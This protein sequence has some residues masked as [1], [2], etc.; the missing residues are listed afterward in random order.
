LISIFLNI[1]RSRHKPIS[2][3]YNL[4]VHLIVL[5]SKIRRATLDVDFARFKSS[6]WL[7]SEASLVDPTSIE[8]SK[9]KI[10]LIFVVTK[11]DFSVLKYSL[12]KALESIAPELRGHIRLIVPTLDVNECKALFA[13]HHTDVRVSDEDTLIDEFDRNVLKEKFGKRYTWVL[14]QVLKVAAV[15][16]SSSKASLIVD[17]DTILLREREWLSASGQQILMPS[18]EFN[19]DYYAFLSRFGLCKNPPEYTFVSHHM[20]I[21]KSFMVDALRVIGVSSIHELVALL[22]SDVDIISQSPVCIDYEL[23]AQFMCKF[24]PKKVVL[25]NWSN[26]GISSRRLT[27]TCD[28]PLKMAILKFLYNSVSF[29]SWS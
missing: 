22:N 6:Q 3:L 7:P 27:R 23:Y 14:Q 4:G 16:D 2:I 9:F 1:F 19:S 24:F 17:A 5:I 8:K 25:E 28:S 11:K 15:L 29:H 10:D 21:Q 18:E 12:P 26:I 20:L 13:N